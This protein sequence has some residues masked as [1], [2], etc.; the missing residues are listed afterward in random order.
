[1]KSS[2]SVLFL[3]ATLAG[4]VAYADCTYPQ[5]PDKLPDGNTAS[6]QDMLAAQ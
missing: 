6:L 3:A 4:G 1:M 5:A 2:V